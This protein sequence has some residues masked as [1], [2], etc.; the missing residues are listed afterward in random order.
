MLKIGGIALKLP[1]GR[2]SDGQQENARVIGLFLYLFCVVS[3]STV[4]R[5]AADTLF[6]SRFDASQLSLMYLPQAGSLILVGFLFQRYGSRIRLD[7]LLFF[8]IPFV[9]LLVVL[10]RI[11]VGLDLLWVYPVIYVGYDVFNFLMIVCFWQFASSVLD[12]RKAKKTIPLVGSG[13]LVGGIVSGFGLKLLSPLVGTDNLIFFYAGLQLIALL[14]VFMVIRMSPNAA[15]IF[16][17]PQP[18]NKTVDGK[19]A[20][21]SSGGLFKNV[22]HLKYVAIMSAALVLSLT[23]IDYQ[24]KVILRGTLQ[25]DALAGFMGSFYGY[26]G[27]CALLVQLFVAGKLV[28]KFGV[29]TS[30]LVFPL[31]LFA[32]SLGVIFFPVLAMAILVKG[33]DKVL[34]DTIYS[35]VNQLIMFPISPKWRNRAKSFLD[36]VVRNGA[37][38]VA[39][40]SL[41]VLSPLL[42]AREFSFII[43]G[44]LGV[45]IFAAIRVKSAYLRMLLSSLETNGSDLQEGEL[46]LMDPASRQLLI[47]A[48][49][50]GDRQ[51]ALYALRILVGLGQFDLSPYIPSLLRHSSS[52]V[53]VEALLYV[54]RALPIGMDEE[55]A[56]LLAE[57]D[58]DQRIKSQALIAIAAYAKEEY[59][60][61]ISERL[62][63]DEVE[64]RAGAIAGL[65]KYYG[66]EGMFRA[67]GTLKA[68]IDSVSEEERTA[69]AALFG[70]IGIR[71]FYKPLI[72]LLQ[73][74]SPEVR[75]CALQSASKLIVPELVPSIVPLLQESRTRPEAIE[76]L[77][78]YEAKVILPLLEPYLDREASSLHVPKVFERMGTQGAFSILFR[79]YDSVRY[80]M[81]DKLLEALAGMRSLEIQVDF[82]ETQ[83]LVLG[84]LESYGQ[85]GEHNVWNPDHPGETEVRDTVEQLRSA[86]IRRAF[87]LLGLNY[88]PKTID[89]VYIGWSEGDVRRQANAAEVMDQMLHGELR[90]ELTKWMLAPKEAA[91]V[92]ASPSASDKSGLLKR[93]HLKWLYEHGDEGLREVIRYAEVIERGD[94]VS[95]ESEVPGGGVQSTGVSDDNALLERMWTMRAL[96]NASLFEG[97]TSKD[98]LPVVRYLKVVEVPAGGVVFREKDPGDSLY[99]VREGRAG[100]YREGVR[101]DERDAGDSFGQTAVLTRRLRT[102]TIRAETDLRLLRLDSSDFYEAMFDR[103]ELALE[104]M[105]RLS[106]KLRSAMVNQAQP[107]SEGS[108]A[109]PSVDNAAQVA[110]ALEIS[111]ISNEPLNQAILRRV[112]VLQKIELFRHLSQDDF[113]RL[114]HRVEEVAYE[115]GEAICRMDEYGDSMFGIIEGG[116]RVHR[117][118]ETLANLGVGQCFGEMAI[119]D[120]GPRSA[121]CTA[122][123]HTVLLRLHRH[124]V[125]SFCFQQIDVLKSMVKVLADRLREIA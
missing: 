14:A 35:S 34:G 45:G 88:D 52:E 3:A 17:N 89:A 109:E 28:S 46:D 112:L 51:Q 75:K 61:M 124:Q 24:F 70:R 38:G 71:E 8:L 83:R 77:A 82:Q 2:T 31:A 113:I 43:A 67:V 91:S 60:E 19:S 92:S 110:A 63:A 78:A 103:T 122:T 25:N 20:K 29:M 42:S 115:P 27:L 73:D 120:S 54:E 16:G 117:G 10:S 80:D 84:E 1:W 7:R 59:L 104:M 62:K 121:D 37:K 90:M 48:L 68:L 49:E 102:A 9:S 101:V 55:L 44:L 65:I 6:L 118:T 53:G 39:A 36:G 12:Q 58:S 56:R 30:I 57:P 18:A 119:I 64:I 47:G 76:A 116:I 11:G 97:F 32:G 23:F 15:E 40:I 74:P 87:Q 108:E 93:E 125:F 22:P 72:P 105:K 100:V 26:S 5:T 96:R 4:G 33:S 66:I 106:R 95:D 123:E 81:R 21:Q 13:G 114:A 41:I 86:M 69:M 107:K 50:S 98:L 99:V 85:F 111:V 79:K 94:T